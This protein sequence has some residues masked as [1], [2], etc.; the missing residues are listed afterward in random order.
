MDVYKNGIFFRIIIFLFQLSSTGQLKHA[1]CLLPWTNLIES[2]GIERKGSKTDID[3]KGDLHTPN[4][5][6]CLSFKNTD[7]KYRLRYK[8]Y[9]RVY[10]III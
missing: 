8:I 9:Y 3:W 1:S 2:G 5:Q 4:F 10:I 7:D 6:T